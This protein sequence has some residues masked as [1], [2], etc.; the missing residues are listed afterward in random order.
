MVGGTDGVKSFL[1]DKLDSV[2]GTKQDDNPYASW[3]TRDEDEDDYSSRRGQK[4]EQQQRGG[5][6]IGGGRTLGSDDTSATKASYLCPS[7]PFKYRMAGFGMCVGVGTL[8]S[9]F[10]WIPAFK[11]D[12][13]TF[14]FIFVIANVVWIL[15]TLFLCGPLRQAKNM[16]DPSRMIAAIVFL[17]GFVMSFVSVFA[18][19][20]AWVAII[21]VIVQWLALAWYCVT[22]IAFA[23]KFFYG[24]FGRK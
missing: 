6:G 2:A 13:G 10:S 11:N 17:I 20:K 3:G 1:S 4:Q 19:K 22:Y 24:L 12:N 9:I 23:R 7:M 14:A 8:L 16:L 21:F 18:I 5:A 15:S